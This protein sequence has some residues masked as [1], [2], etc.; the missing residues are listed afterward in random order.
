MEHAS[1]GLSAIVELLAFYDDINPR[2]VCQIDLVLVLVSNQGSL[3]VLCMQNYKS[4][5]AAVTICFTL[6]NIQTDIFTHT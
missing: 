4:L 6:V 3:L 2:K 1:R 5:C